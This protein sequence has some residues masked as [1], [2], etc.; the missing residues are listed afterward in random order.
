MN[1]RKKLLRSAVL[2]GCVF[3][4]VLRAS[5]VRVTPQNNSLPRYA[6]GRSRR[7]EYRELDRTVEERRVSAAQSAKPVWVHSVRRKH[8]TILTLW[9]GHGFSRAESTKLYLGLQPLRSSFCA[10][11]IVRI[12]FQGLASPIASN[13]VNHERPCSGGQTGKRVWI[14]ACGES[15]GKGTASAVPKA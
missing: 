9:E 13:V 8:Q 7:A 5:A 6:S 4:F 2:P 1:D 12:A 15:F 3:R 11:Y 14:T 10:E